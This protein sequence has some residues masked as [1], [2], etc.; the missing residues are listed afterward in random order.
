MTR[1]PSSPVGG[2]SLVM[3]ALSLERFPMSKTELYYA[4]GDIDVDDASGDTRPLRNVLDRI[5]QQT[6]L[7]EEEVLI[8]V[9]R[10]LDPANR[11]AA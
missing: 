2:I 5:D 9:N 4:V 11:S 1:N 7:S 3:E 6:F 8:A 10:E